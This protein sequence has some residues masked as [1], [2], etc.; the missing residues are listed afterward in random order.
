M[1]RWRVVVL[2]CCC[3]SREGVARQGSAGLLPVS[4]AKIGPFVTR[5]SSGCLGLDAAE[6]GPFVARV[7]L[8]SS[9]VWGRREVAA[10]CG[11]LADDDAADDF[12]YDDVTTPRADDDD[13][14]DGGGG[15]ALCRLKAAAIVAGEANN[16]LLALALL[17]VSRHSLIGARPPPRER[18]ATTVRRW[19]RVVGR[20]VVAPVS[21]RSRL[22]RAAA[23]TWRPR[24]RVVATC[25]MG[26]LGGS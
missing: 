25:R 8:F 16:L 1:S 20:R 17:P 23:T 3:R 19:L 11:G 6:I 13:G 2:L 5:F 14:D 22:W 26:D 12:F 18:A 7:S 24:D 9:H 4:K 15:P 10:A 21:R